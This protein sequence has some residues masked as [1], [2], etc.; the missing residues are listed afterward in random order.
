MRLT[1]IIILGVC[2]ALY[3]F[4]ITYKLIS[5]TK[6][7]NSIIIL[8]DSIKQKIRFKKETVSEIISSYC[9]DQNYKF[10]FNSVLTTDLNDYFRRICYENDQLLID[11]EQKNVLYDFFIGLGKSD[12]EGQINHCENYKDIFQK[13][14]LE[15]ENESKKKIKLYPSLFLLSGMLVILIL[16]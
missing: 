11:K 13:G 5:A 4:Y 10:L 2:I 6:Q 1:G 8:I 3:G 14:L 7:L 9:K 16:F 15:F 12:L